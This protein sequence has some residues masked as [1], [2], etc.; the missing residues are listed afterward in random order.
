[1]QV[2]ALQT[3][4]PACVIDVFPPTVLREATVAIENM[5]PTLVTDCA[6][7]E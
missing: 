4:R 2:M 3:S 5:V 1:M 6:D 7:A